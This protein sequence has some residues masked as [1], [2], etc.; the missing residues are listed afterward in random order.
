MLSSPVDRLEAWHRARFMKPWL[1]PL[2]ITRTLVLVA[3]LMAL[4][5]VF[6]NVKLRYDQGQVWKA[7]PEITEIAGSMSF[8]TADAPYFLAHAANAKKG[9]SP[10]A[11]A[12]KRNYPNALKDQQLPVNDP[13]HTKLPLLSNLIALMS[14][15]STPGDLLTAAH[16]LLIISSGITA[17]FIIIAFGAAGYWFEGTVAAMGGGLSSAYLVRSSF[18][19]IDT[20]QLNLGLMY[21]LFGLVLFSARSKTVFW[22]FFW[23]VFAGLTAKIFMS[24]Y[25][26]P[27]L[28]WLAMI[29]YCWLLMVL[30][31]NVFM[32]FSCLLLF[33]LISP[34]DLPNPLNST[35]I[36]THVSSGHFKFPNTLNTIS[37]TIRVSLPNILKMVA[38]SVEMGIVCILGLTLWLIRHPVLAVAYGPLALFASLN[39][40]IG[41]RAVFYSAPIFWFGAAFL[42]SSVGRYITQSSIIKPNPNSQL[43]SKHTLASIVVATLS[44]GLAWV[45]SPTE[46]LPQPTFPKPV[47]EGLLK[48]K[49]LAKSDNSVVASW[50]D[51]GYA[52]MFFN[53]LP[54]LHDGGNQAGPTTHFFADAL[55]QSDQLKTVQTLQFLINEGNAGIQKH[56][57]KASLFE[58]ISQR[59]YP[60]SSDIYLVLTDQMAS[61]IPAISKIGNWDIETGKPITLPNNNNKSY[62][63]YIRVGCN[64]R[65]FPSMIECGEANINLDQG[66]LNSKTSLLGWAQSHNGFMAKVRNYNENA[67]LAVQTLHVNKRLSLQLMHNQLYRSTYNSLFHLG[68]IKV[69]SIELI[70][71]KYPHIRIYKIN[72]KGN[73]S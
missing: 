45:N 15:S 42:I 50:W 23:C 27:E 8:S 47:L 26:K 51:Y 4:L 40:L 36:Q 24:W 70:Y 16:R 1:G 60:Y 5:T 20:D 68:L 19:R 44:L 9:L 67:T 39:F 59:N 54:T 29:S 10:E 35:Y 17:L 34:T 25:G 2:A 6:A 14:S 21:L 63:E 32:T 65:E 73:G 7:N 22:T 38:G 13:A 48:L 28:I 62:V 64:F 58:H 3:I 72:G 49:A 31:R 12:L 71:D 56:T 46:Y 43:N 61:W 55:L 30:K 37:E 41:N 11:F 33:Y 18:G 52:S 69:P 53:Q 57:S 66:T